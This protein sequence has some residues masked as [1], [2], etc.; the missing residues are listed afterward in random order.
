MRSDELTNLKFQDV[1][2]NGNKYIAIVRDTKTTID[3]Q[4]IIGSYFYNIVKKYINMRPSEQFTD[5]FFIVWRNGKC[6]RQV[7]GKNKIGEVPKVIATF[8]NLPDPKTYTG[9]CFRRT[10]AT[11]LSDSGASVQM[12]KQLGG[13]RSES[14]ALGYVENSM[15]VKE[16]IFKGIVHASTSGQS[17]TLNSPLTSGNSSTHHPPS[18]SAQSSTCHPLRSDQSTITKPPS[19]TACNS[20]ALVPLIEKENLG[21]KPNGFAQSSSE[22]QAIQRNDE[23]C[24]LQWEDFSDDFTTESLLSGN[25][26]PQFSSAT[27]QPIVIPAHSKLST[28]EN[29]ESNRFEVDGRSE[30]GFRSA[31]KHF[32]EKAAVK[33][34]FNDTEPVAKKIKA[35]IGGENAG[36]DSTVISN[37]KLDV[38]SGARFINCVFQNCTFNLNPINK[39]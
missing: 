9:H 34:K 12:L 18:T 17:K 11:L 22:D 1:E 21:K 39:S 20:K 26:S 19:S 35:D 6:V 24:E 14:V 30:S 7:I 4:F 13:W 25:L 28:A 32:T 33:L 5:R 37:Q 10:A 38:D 23:V 36:Q 3:R 2:D 15:H 31:K 8:L 27:G 16:K 29:L